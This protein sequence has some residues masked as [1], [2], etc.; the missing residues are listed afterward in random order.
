[1]PASAAQRTV[2]PQ[3]RPHHTMLDPF[4]R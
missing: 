3:H 2:R 4:S 1:V